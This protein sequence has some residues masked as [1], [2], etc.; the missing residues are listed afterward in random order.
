MGKKSELMETGMLPV[1][2]V[3]IDPMLEPNDE[4]VAKACSLMRDVWYGSMA[5]ELN[6]RAAK[7]LA[8]GKIS[9]AEH[10]AIVAENQK[11][12]KRHRGQMYEQKNV[13]DYVR[14]DSHSYRGNRS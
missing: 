9:Q 11:I 4:Q 12:D 14:K 2:T 6:L 13:F 7:L 8:D 5:Q 10:D 1:G 3:K